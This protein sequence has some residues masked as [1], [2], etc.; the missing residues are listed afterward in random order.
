MARPWVFR[1]AITWKS[2]SVSRMLRLLVGSSKAM[3]LAS[4]VRALAISTIC[5]WPMARSET[6]ARG[7]MS[8]PRSA[9]RERLCSIK[10]C[11]STKPMLWGR[12]AQIQV[13]RHGQLR[14]Q[15]EFLVNDR[16]AGVDGLPRRLEVLNRAAQ[17]QFAAVGLVDAAEDLQ[18]RA[19]ARAVLA[20][21]GVNAR[22]AHAKT[23]VVQGFHAWKRLA[24]G[25]KLQIRRVQ[26]DQTAQYL[27]GSR[28]WAF[29]SCAKF[30][31]VIRMPVVYFR[32]SGSL[33]SLIH[34]YMVSAVP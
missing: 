30:S 16:H 23:D 20:D 25:A 18:Q 11:R 15:V 6:L 5:R 28:P 10:R 13:L 14:H 32:N 3:T 1:R 12:V 26:G 33:P 9:R 17:G 8:W 27:L 19:L 24:D 7:S 4:R 31:R 22:L 21:Q 2:C 29:I 34:L